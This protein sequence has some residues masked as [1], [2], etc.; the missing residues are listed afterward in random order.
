M[1][2][3][4][5]VTLFVRGEEESSDD[6]AWDD[7]ILVEEYD[8]SVNPLKNKVAKLMGVSEGDGASASSKEN[9][10]NRS[11]RLEKKPFHSWEIGSFCR[12][13]YSADK[14]FYEAAILSIN[15]KRG[16]CW[17]KYI[18]YDNQEEVYLDGILPSEGRLARQAQEEQAVIENFHEVDD[19][20]DTEEMIPSDSN[21]LRKNCKK[22]RKKG[23]S[24]SSGYKQFN[25]QK[26]KTPSPINR[27]LSSQSAHANEGQQL[28]WNPQIPD[29]NSLPLPPPPPPHIFENLTSDDGEAL[30]AMLMSWYMSGYHTGYYY[31]L[32]QAKS[33]QSNCHSSRHHGRW[34]KS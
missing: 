2:A 9:A 29:A 10:K 16:T 7:T 3:F 11:K 15:K 27:P 12:A 13:K 17:V 21:S 18:G 28:G 32:K 34:R 14:V 31:G 19:T 5:P 1:S 20:E 25:W 22:L 26:D 33:Q 30:S 6:D 23:G 24:P 4:E 8:R